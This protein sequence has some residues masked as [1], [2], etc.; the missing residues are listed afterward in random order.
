MSDNFGW[1]GGY[2]FGTVPVLPVGFR[3][4]RFMQPPP[5]A[6]AVRARAAPRAYVICPRWRVGCIRTGGRWWSCSDLRGR[7]W[8]R[9][10]R[11]ARLVDRA[12]EIQ[13]HA[14]AKCMDDVA[15]LADGTRPPRFV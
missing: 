1:A 7:A 14:R 2:I 5:H 10:L 8:L 13:P 6:A 11:S 9:P 3:V 4:G 12:L 15:L